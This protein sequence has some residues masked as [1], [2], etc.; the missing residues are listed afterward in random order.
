VRMGYP[1]LPAI[2][3][4]LEFS[5]SLFDVAKLNVNLRTCDR[6]YIKL[7]EFKA[8]T[9]DEI[10]ENVCKISWSEFL[11]KNAKILVNGNAVKSQIYAIS[12]CQKIIKKAIIVSLQ[13]SYHI[14]YFS[15]TGA[16][17]QIEFKLFKDT[18]KILLNTSGE[19]LHK[20]GYRYLVGIAPIK[21]TLASSLV[22]LSDYYYERPLADP[23]CGS[24]TILIEGAMI[25]LNI[26]PNKD[27]QFAFDKWDFFDKNIKKEVIS[28]AVN[29]EKRDRKIEIFG[30]DIDSKAIK[31]ATHHIERTGL[32]DYIKVK[33]LPVKNFETELKNGT[34]VTNPPYGERVYDRREAEE[35]Y[36]DLRFAF[37]KLDNWSL[38]LI[39]SAN[40]FTKCFGKKA[41][42][43]RKLYNSNK[44]CKYYYF[45]KDREKLKG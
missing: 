40:N 45:Y 11:P 18:M 6:V 20:R 9:F 28:E 37:D 12:A 31:L 16:E 8:T 38:F 25:G 24:G 36:K 22:L 7:L 27:R 44:E 26:A 5:G 2:N 32:K 4:E 42:R 15:E 3:G 43:D 21:E 1:D 13:K 14:E 39:T 30:S 41:D 23:F 29:N 10:F 17:F 34:I 33:T 19:G 35:C